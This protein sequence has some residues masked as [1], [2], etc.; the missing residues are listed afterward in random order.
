VSE[1]NRLTI[2]GTIVEVGSRRVSP[3]GIPQ[4]R[5]TV[6]HRSRQVE[7]GVP[8]EARCRIEVKI[9]GVEFAALLRTLVVGQRVEVEGFLTRSGFKGSEASIVVHATGIR[10]TSDATG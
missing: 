9:A 8:R 3:A 4:Q 2:T 5:I 10:I 1:T 7:A 6:E